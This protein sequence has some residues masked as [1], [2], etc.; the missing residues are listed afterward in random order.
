[1]LHVKLRRA[2]FAFILASHPSGEAWLAMS[3]FAFQATLDKLRIIILWL[4]WF[5]RRMVYQAKPQFIV[6]KFGGV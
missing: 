2:F 3:N 5:L 4:A 1:M 6:A